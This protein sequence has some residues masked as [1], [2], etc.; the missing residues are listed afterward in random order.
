MFPLPLPDAFDMIGRPQRAYQKKKKNNVQVH[1]QRLLMETE[2]LP[3]TP[4]P[5][6][7]FIEL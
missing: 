3:F 6:I 7:V 2:Y 1:F 5:N 4:W